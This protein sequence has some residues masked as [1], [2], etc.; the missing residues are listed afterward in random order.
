MDLKENN[1]VHKDNTVRTLWIDMDGVLSIY[2]RK[3]YPQIESDER[4]YNPYVQP[5]LFE[6]PGQRYFK[7]CDADSK[8][9][10][11]LIWLLNNSEFSHIEQIYI[12]SAVSVAA[13]I[14]IEHVED[15]L[16][17][18]KENLNIKNDKARTCK[19]VPTTKPKYI[20]A[21]E[22]LG[23][24]LTH[25]DVLIDDFNKNLEA[26]DQNGGR[27][28]KYGN[29]INDHTSFRGLTIPPETSSLE[30]LKFLKLL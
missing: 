3:A 30:I 16:Y 10:Q 21:K 15:K 4:P 11:V 2:D 1:I 8:M 6:T 27:A 9:I 19:F 22:L 28:I 13:P 7:T 17:W 14:Y 5:A 24:D 29:S 20:V 23:R 26:W 18:L 25:Q 12:V